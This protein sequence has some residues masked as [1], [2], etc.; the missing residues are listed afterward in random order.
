MI[1]VQMVPPIAEHTANGSRAAAIGVEGTDL[2]IM[3]GTFFSEKE[4]KN[5]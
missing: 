2:V 5:P 1:T 4:Y 3:K